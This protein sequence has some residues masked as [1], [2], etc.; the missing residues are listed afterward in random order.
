VQAALSAV[1]YSPE[2]QV[3]APSY[4]GVTY[5]AVIFHSDTY[6]QNGRLADT[7]STPLL[8]HYSDL[9]DDVCHNPDN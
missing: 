6:L 9:F 1:G 8:P 5:L 4:E 2:V 3:V 7:R